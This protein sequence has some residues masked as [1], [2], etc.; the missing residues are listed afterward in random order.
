MHVL[1]TVG[2]KHSR[3]PLYKLLLHDGQS[4][5]CWATKL[6]DCGHGDFLFLLWAFMLVVTDRRRSDCCDWLLPCDADP[7]IQTIGNRSRPNNKKEAGWRD[8]ATKIRYSRYQLARPSQNQEGFI[9][10]TK[11]TNIILY[12]LPD[13]SKPRRSPLLP[14]C[15]TFYLKLCKSE[16]LGTN[17]CGVCALRRRRR[18]P[19]L[20]RSHRIGLNRRARTTP[21]F[22]HI[23]E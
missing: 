5:Q 10:K 15:W 4:I 16:I 20:P 21:H 19:S 2:C 1:L 22:T 7:Q 18:F 13:L 9:C 12:H 23:V 3:T 14:H 8:Q 17:F 6:A 11:N